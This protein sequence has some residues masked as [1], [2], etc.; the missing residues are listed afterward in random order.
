MTNQI[1]DPPN[2]YDAG[3]DFDYTVWTADSEITLVNVPWN[4]DYRDVVSLAT[5]IDAFIDVQE[6]ALTRI[7]MPYMRVNQPILLDVA[8]EQAYRYN[9]I[10]VRN[11]AQPIP[12]SAPRSY[13]YFI[14]DIQHAS[15]GATRVM[16][17][18]DVWQSFGRGVEF[19][20]SFVERGHIGI[21]NENAFDNYGRDYLTIQEGLETGGE[22]VIGSTS[23]VNVMSAP[24]TYD[25]LVTSTIDLLADNGTAAAPT[26]K[27]A[28]G[29]FFQGL[30]NG[31][32]QYIFD[33]SASLSAFLASITGKPWVGNGIVSIT[34][35]PNITRWIP[36]FAYEPS[37]TPTPVP[38]NFATMTPLSHT[39]RT[40]WRDGILSLI[41]TKYRHL[42]KFLTY[43][44]MAI[45][46]TGYSGTPVILKPENWNNDDAVLTEMTSLV[47]PNQRIA[48]FPDDYNAR[49]TGGSDEGIDRATVIANFPSMA[50][51]NNQSSMYF[52]ANR[53][54]I[55][56]AQQA[57]DWSQQK[58]LY[59]NQVTYDQTSRNIDL[60]ERLNMN[61]RNADILQTNLANESAAWG[62]VF[63]GAQSVIGGAG[64]GALGG[65]AGAIAGG[66]GGALNAIGNAFNT[67]RSIDV[68]NQSLAI[69]DAQNVYST[70]QSAQVGRE[71]RD[72]NKALGDYAARG[73]YANQIA[74]I[75]AKI[76][77]SHFVPPSVAGQIGGEAFNMIFGGNRVELRWKMLD[78]A[79]I[80]AIGD[81]WLRYGYAVSQFADIPQSLMCMSKFTYWKLAETY[82]RSS[83]VPEPIK[84]AI[85]GILEKGVTVWNNPSDIGRIEWD[86]NA[87]LEGITL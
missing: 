3:L 6:T 10:R 47:A 18:L 57:A 86:D 8:F 53:N 85:R 19:G 16:V 59:G 48:M 44:Y 68:A 70:S 56:F 1:T 41:P 62:A 67:M 71:N 73:D 72:S 17:Q 34:L 2:T 20:K 76:Q 64:M 49:S 11:M 81:F 31:L 38:T 75:Q 9:Y 12:G 46:M 51:V 79:H 21:A 42:K 5:D 60:M 74:G 58:A 30:A 65:P 43:P 22:Y 61:S 45:E 54:Q 35:I 63:N 50:A 32:N 77:D 23:T 69:R 26:P 36:G 40:N 83:A 52:A 39:V 80:R 33:T 87:P 15:P 27:S 78:T 28:T 82:F 13:Y 7:K 29:S 24:S 4:S 84:Q 55:A 25:I 66:A 37:G 14:V